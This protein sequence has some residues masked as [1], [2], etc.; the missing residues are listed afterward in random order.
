MYYI[1]SVHGRGGVSTR[2]Y[3]IKLSPILYKQPCSASGNW[4]G[5]KINN[6]LSV[7]EPQLNNQPTE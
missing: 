6:K 3:S 2:V 1:V 7:A 4:A 5:D